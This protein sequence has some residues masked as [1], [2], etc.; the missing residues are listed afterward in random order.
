MSAESLQEIFSEGGV[1]S[2]AFSH[3]NPRA[4]QL[5]MAQAISEGIAEHATVIAQAGTGTGKTFAYLIPALLSG[6]KTLISTGTKAL[7]DQL[8]GRD[9]P[10]LRKALGMPIDAT[11]LKGRS[12]YICLYYLECLENDFHERG[13]TPEEKHYFEQVKEFVSVG[14]G[15][16]DISYCSSVPEQHS[17]WSKVTA[18]SE[19]CLGSACPHAQ[20][21]FANQAR[22]KAMQ[23]DIVVMNHALF[24]SLQ[25][26]KQRMSRDVLPESDIV[27][28]DEAHQLA[29]AVTNHYGDRLTMT[30]LRN[31]VLEFN[32]QKTTQL[33]E[34]VQVYE[35]ARRLD[36]HVVSLQNHIQKVDQTEQA[37]SKAL[38]EDQ[39]FQDQL[40]VLRDEVKQVATSLG[41]VLKTHFSE[42]DDTNEEKLQLT[43]LL[44]QI[45]AYH[46]VLI[47][48]CQP[49]R[50]K[51]AY[52][53]STTKESFNL[54]IAP[55]D[56]NFFG[57]FKREEQTWVLA[58]ATLFVLGSEQHIIRQL[59]LHDVRAYQFDSPFDYE[60]QAI[61]HIPRHLPNVNHESFGLE[62]L[63][64][65]WHFIKENQ[66]GTLILA[67]SLKQMRFY[68]ETLRLGFQKAGIDRTVFLQGE[69]SRA[70]LLQNFRRSK[71]GVLIGS[72][73]LREGVDFPGEM[74]TLLLID[75][76]PFASPDDPVIEA[77]TEKLKKDGYNPFLLIQLPDMAMHLQQSVGRLIRTEQDYGMVMI[78]DARLYQKSYGQS[79]LSNL[80][81][82][83]RI[84]HA[85]EA[86]EAFKAQRGLVNEASLKDSEISC[87]TNK[88]G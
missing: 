1:L 46:E 33:Q 69:E 58:S 34:S 13:L 61:L 3:F 4:S 45:Q 77:R 35:A 59:G 57:D 48:W 80:P 43:V 75:K 14:R 63:R 66:G 29:Q 20:Q 25:R 42:V 27:I 15:L 85:R 36:K 2:R 11:V 50:H 38:Y 70:F 53:V 8:F 19:S 30:S 81:A 37:R 82:F 72:A 84:D 17:F 44:D 23:A 87:S 55:I 10:S 39:V 65:A 64:H 88:Q 32:A 41:L 7:Q 71:N 28:F 47:A 78:G 21:C 60:K 52:W 40:I 86:Y 49:D 83:R 74:L 22:E 26:V 56:L 62:F 18:T 12:N 9:L 76:L 67:S 24:V 54:N 51:Y 6:K 5:A 79:V 16:G 73:S 31:W 68:A